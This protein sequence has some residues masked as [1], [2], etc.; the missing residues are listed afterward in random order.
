MLQEMHIASS[1]YVGFS[2]F[3]E[4]GRQR[5][6]PGLVINRF[7]FDRGSII[8]ELPDVVVENWLA[9][10]RSETS[11][12]SIESS[13]TS[14]YHGNIHTEVFAG[15]GIPYNGAVVVTAAPDMTVYIWLHNGAYRLVA[16]TLE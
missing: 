6:V 13:Y 16:A 3:T 14:R 15:F 2:T 8:G 9:R 4:R 11:R 7:T 1:Q 10:L 5:L 12:A